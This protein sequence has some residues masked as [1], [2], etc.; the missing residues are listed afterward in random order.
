MSVK[1]QIVE[2]NELLVTASQAYHQFD[3]PIMSDSEYDQKYRQLKELVQQNSEYLELATILQ[4]V[5]F[6]P[7]FSKIEHSHRLYSLD[8]AFSYEDLVAFDQRVKNMVGDCQYCVEL[9]IDGLAMSIEYVAGILKLGATRGNGYVGEN[10]TDNIK[11][12]KTLPKKLNKPLDLILRGEVFLSKKELE[13]I[14]VERK[15]LGLNEFVNCRNAAAGSIRQLDSMESAK[16]NL[17][18]F[19]YTLIEPEK[20][21]LSG[22]YETLQQLKQ[23]GFKVN[24]HVFLANDILSAYHIV[25][26]IEQKKDSYPFDIDGV[27]IKVNNFRQQEECGYTIRAPRFA[28]AYKFAPEIV[29]SKIEDIK[30]T[31]GRTG[32]I[33]PNAVLSPVFLANT[34]VKAAT[35]HNF[36]NIR[37]KDI[38]INDTCLVQ[39]AGEIIP[40][41]I[42]VIKEKRNGSEIIYDLPT[43]CP[44]C[45]EELLIDSDIVDIYCVNQMC[46]ARILAALNH[47]VSLEAMNIEGFG[48]ARIKQIHELGILNSIVDFYNLYNYRLELE[49]LDKMG[50]KSVQNI[51]DNIEKSKQLPLENV[52]FGLNIVHVGK[53]V[54][55]ILAQHFQ[56]IDQLMTAKIEDLVAI[57]E[58]GIKIANSVVNF[59]SHENNKL[60]IRQLKE[61]GLNFNTSLKNIILDSEFSGKIVVLTG[62]LENYSRS[63]MTKLLENMGAKVTSS[64]SKKTDYVVAGQDAGSKLTK[65]QQYNIKVLTESDVIKMIGN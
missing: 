56:T 63:E 33:V 15:E 53:K 39:K 1:Q 31:V 48:P 40:E 3:N 44:V 50:A 59:F 28:I 23:W 43:N 46:P 14:N 52:L 61:S 2:L 6:L 54:A 27:V 55:T 49:S 4:E 16:R 58:I 26:E 65:A 34:T 24:E 35:L 13:R 29:E 17:D 22:Q 64:V 10:V 20:Y 5:G 51:L 30:L 38:R 42:G 19:W 60:I 41:V 45:G 8:N 36:D 62:S 25:E 21:Q 47:F 11:T 57:D 18:A 7:T 37:N 12:I 9:K 32:K